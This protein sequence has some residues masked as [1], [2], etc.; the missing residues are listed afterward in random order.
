MIF[1]SDRKAHH[2]TLREPSQKK[3][4]TP[5][6]RAENAGGSTTSDTALKSL[7]LLMKVLMLPWPGLVLAARE[8]YV[9]ACPS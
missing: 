2:R 3:M 6:Q 7:L 9:P 5:E 4:Y 8:H 1:L